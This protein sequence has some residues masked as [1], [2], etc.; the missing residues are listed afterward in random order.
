MFSNS[1][2]VHQLG[3]KFAIIVSVL[4]LLKLLLLLLLLSSLSLLL[5]F[6]TII[7]WNRYCNPVILPIPTYFAVA[8]S[9]S[10]SQS[11]TLLKRFD[12]FGCHLAG[13]LVW[14]DDTLCYMGSDSAPPG[15]PCR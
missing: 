7:T 10:L 1:T 11:F 9:V 8:R 2:K 15:G 3:E 12:G 14:S 5:L 6:L 13:M 4:F